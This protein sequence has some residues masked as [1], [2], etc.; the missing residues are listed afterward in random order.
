MSNLVCVAD[1]D[2]LIALNLEND[3]H[4]NKA[5]IISAHL[6]AKGVTIIFPITVFPETITFLKRAANQPKKAHDINKK[7]Q[8]GAFTVEYIDGKILN[9][10]TKY[11]DQADSKK[12]TFFDAL[13]AATAERL[14]ADAIFS[15]DTWYKKLGFTLVE[16]FLIV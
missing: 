3:V 10:A 6:L 11:F 7:L 5:K 14:K 15:F 2:A 9:L 16:D 4:H 1:T 8:A 12:N 13:V